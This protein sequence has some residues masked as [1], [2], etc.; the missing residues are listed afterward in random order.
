LLK[1][2]LRI[3]NVLSLL[4]KAQMYITGIA[5]VVIVW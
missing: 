5:A 4:D 1:H 2:N 3:A